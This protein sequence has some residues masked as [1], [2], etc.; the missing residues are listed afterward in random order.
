MRNQ[1][2]FVVVTRIIHALPN[3]QLVGNHTGDGKDCTEQTPNKYR[4]YSSPVQHVAQAPFRSVSTPKL[5]ASLASC[6]TDNPLEP[7]CL[8]Y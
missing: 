4:R 1:L 2:H 7:E 8:R 5:R 3:L 6:R